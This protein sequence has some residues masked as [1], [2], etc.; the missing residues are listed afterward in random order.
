M[1]HP[2]LLV[3]IGGSLALTGTLCSS[4]T[5]KLAPYLSLYAGMNGIG[6]GMCYFVPLVCAWEYFPHK[7]GLMTGI[8]IGAYGFGSFF[9]SLLST[10]LVNPDHL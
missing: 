6:C 8:I 1:W 2:K 5:K 3:G 10:K 9:F 4:F 7:K